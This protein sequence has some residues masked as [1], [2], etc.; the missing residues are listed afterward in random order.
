MQ[1]GTIDGN[2]GSAV[3]KPDAMRFWTITWSGGTVLPL[4][5]YACLSCGLVWTNASTEKLQ[6]FK[7]KHCQKPEA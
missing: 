6:D 7:N 1:E 2:D 3:F 4:K 5:A